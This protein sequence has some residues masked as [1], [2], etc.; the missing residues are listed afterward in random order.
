MVITYPTVY[1]TII[2]VDLIVIANCCFYSRLLATL[3]VP[4]L[5]ILCTLFNPYSFFAF[6]D[7]SSYRSE[8][9]VLLGHPIHMFKIDSIYYESN[10]IS[11]EF[12]IHMSSHFVQIG[13]YFVFTRWKRKKK[14]WAWKFWTFRILRIEMSTGIVCISCSIS[15]FA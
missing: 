14:I 11:G 6:T 7:A 2:V 5:Y 13:T 1:F 3:L 15:M 8:L 4:K 10:K 12:R 9:A